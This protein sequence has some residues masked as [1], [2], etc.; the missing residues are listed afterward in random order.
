[1]PTINGANVVAG[2]ILL[3]LT[4]GLTLAV[5][6]QEKAY[7]NGQIH[8]MIPYVVRINSAEQF[9]YGAYTGHVPVEMA[10]GDDIR[11]LAYRIQSL[12][13]KVAH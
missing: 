12:E 13:Q 8:I 5:K 1:M 2:V 7:L 9:Q 3:I 11:E 4:I 10:I 6:A